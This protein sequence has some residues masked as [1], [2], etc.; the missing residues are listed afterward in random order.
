[1][2]TGL[3]NLAEIEAWR[4]TL[5]LTLRLQLNHPNAVFRRWQASRQAPT[6]GG[7]G[8][9]AR[10]GLRE[11]VLRLQ[12]ELDAAQRE[13]ARLRDGYDAANDWDWED[14]PEEIAEAMLRS[15]PAKAKRIGA[16]IL[17][18][19]KSTARNAG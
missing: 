6:K 18:L 13:I 2:Q 3:D 12:S 4:N 8:S 14:T 10:P 5:G 11:E 16:A 17:V 9:S 1:L 15:H 7:N 19:S